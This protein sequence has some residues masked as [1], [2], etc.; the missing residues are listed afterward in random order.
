MLNLSGYLPQLNSGDK[1]N[2]SFYVP[3]IPEISKN[4]KIV[5]SIDISDSSGFMKKLYYQIRDSTTFKFYDYPN[6]EIPS[7]FHVKINSIFLCS[8]T[9][10]HLT[11]LAGVGSSGNPAS[12]MIL[13][14]VSSRYTFQYTY[15]LL[16]TSL[17]N[18]NSGTLGD[19]I[20]ALQTYKTG[21]F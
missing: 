18:I 2:Y 19:Q 10:I 5:F 12:M 6:L 15:L 11:I 13:T 21:G 16:D 8:G 14:D 4:R 9:D 17:F 20:L 3:Q 1:I 7:G